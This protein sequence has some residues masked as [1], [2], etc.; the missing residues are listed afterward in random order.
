[1]SSNLVIGLTPTFLLALSANYV[2]AMHHQF[3]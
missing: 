2:V 1:M 3:T